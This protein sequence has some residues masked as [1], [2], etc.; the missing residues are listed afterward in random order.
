[1]AA[2]TSKIF[3]VAVDHILRREGN[4]DLTFRLDAESICQDA[5]S[6]ECPAAAALVLI[7]NLGLAL[8]ELGSI[9]VKCRQ[10]SISRDELFWPLVFGFLIQFAL[11]LTYEIELEK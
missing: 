11:G 10:I 5:R 1:M 7:K 9:I 4:F 6:G 8:R 2:A 3:I